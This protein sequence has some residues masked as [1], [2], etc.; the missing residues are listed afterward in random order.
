MEKN[1]LPPLPPDPT[2]AF[3]QAEHARTLALLDEVGSPGTPAFDEGRILDAI[4][5]LHEIRA[6]MP[7]EIRAQYVTPLDPHEDIPF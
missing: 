4:D 5:R 6:A 7:P 1:P 3:L 2:V